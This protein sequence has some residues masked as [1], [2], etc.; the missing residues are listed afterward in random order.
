M[1]LIEV[2]AVTIL[3]Q[4][5]SLRMIGFSGRN[6]SSPIPEIEMADQKLFL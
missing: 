4:P 5:E 6:S 2:H 3:L 1:K